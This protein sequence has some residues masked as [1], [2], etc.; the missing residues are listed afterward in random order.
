M[1]VEKEVKEVKSKRVVLKWRWVVGA[2]NATY[3][4]K[5]NFIS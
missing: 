3:E 5:F 1:D 4:M 2:Y